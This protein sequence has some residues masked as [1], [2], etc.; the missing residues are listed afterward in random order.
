MR[1]PW[2]KVCRQFWSLNRDAVAKNPTQH[3]FG[4]SCLV[5][6][7]HSIL[8]LKQLT[9]KHPTPDTKHFFQQLVFQLFT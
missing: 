7:R 1:A 6:E 4:V 3:V 2:K 5:L 8:Y 9:R